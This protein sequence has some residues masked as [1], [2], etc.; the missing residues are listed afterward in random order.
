VSYR[1]KGFWAEVVKEVEK[2]RVDKDVW[3]TVQ[4]GHNDQKSDKGISTAQL[5]ANLEK[6]VKELR[7]LKATAVSFD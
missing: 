4:F 3:V 5:E 6:M 2:R 7:D 1:Q